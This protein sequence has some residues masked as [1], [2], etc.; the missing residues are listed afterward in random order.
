VSAAATSRRPLGTS[1]DGALGDSSLGVG[2]AEVAVLRA[3][4]VAR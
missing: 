2:T 4:G 3:D 1:D